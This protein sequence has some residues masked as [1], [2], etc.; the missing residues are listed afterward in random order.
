MEPERAPGPEIGSILAGR[1]AAHRWASS[2]L[3]LGG[4]PGY[5]YEYAKLNNYWT[6]AYAR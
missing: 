5:D 4:P 3:L 6:W 1:G 2:S